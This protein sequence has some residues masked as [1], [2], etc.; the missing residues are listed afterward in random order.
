[1]SELET[2]IGR[3]GVVTLS[4]ICGGR[5]L[6]IPTMSECQASRRARARFVALVGITFAEN[7]ITAF[8]GQRLYVPKGPNFV[9]RPRHPIDSREVQR[10]TDQGKTADEIAQSLNCSTR[11]IYAK[12]SNIR[13]GNENE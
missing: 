13:K 9:A 3:R 11:T 5:H 1:M 6:N 10:L 2:A 7:L 8:P 12:R 4:R